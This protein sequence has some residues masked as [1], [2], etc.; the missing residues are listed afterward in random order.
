M[1][2]TRA[3]AERAKWV[4]MQEG[5]DGLPLSIYE[6]AIA[7]SGGNLRRLL[8]RISSGAFKADARAQMLEQVKELERDYAMV[9]S[10]KGEA[11]AAKRR[12]NE[13]ARAELAAT[14]ASLA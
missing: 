8:Q 6:A 2:D 1:T 10:T 7:N 14:I 4:A 9:A 3:F 12:T 13:A 11:A 5:I